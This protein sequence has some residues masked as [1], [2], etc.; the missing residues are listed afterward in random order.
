M[1]TF[2]GDYDKPTFGPSML[3]NR[4]KVNEHLP[5]CHSF[6]REGVWQYL[7]DCSHEMAGQH[8]PMIPPDPDMSFQRRHGWHLYPWTDD[9]GYPL[10]EQ[11]D[12]DQG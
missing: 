4:D 2:N 10:K 12:G 7:G 9:E 8:V 3:S 6:L 5:V 1:W 11:N